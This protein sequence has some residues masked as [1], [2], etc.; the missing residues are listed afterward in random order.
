[1]AKDVSALRLEPSTT[2]EFSKTQTLQIGIATILVLEYSFFLSEQGTQESAKIIESAAAEYQR[3]GTPAAVQEA[4]KDV[5]SQGHAHE[6]LCK[7]IIDI[8][9]RNRMSKVVQE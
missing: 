5:L 7:M 1:M 9:L 3:S 2:G 6:E 8:I 4:V